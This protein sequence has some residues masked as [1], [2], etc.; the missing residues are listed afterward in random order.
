MLRGLPR[1][2]SAH[3]DGDVSYGVCLLRPIRTALAGRSATTFESLG[4]LLSSHR[5]V[6]RVSLAALS[7]T[8]IVALGQQAAPTIQAGPEPAPLVPE[9]LLPQS[10]GVSV[11]SGDAIT[12]TF[13]T[14]MDPA[15]V[16]AALQVLPAHK[17]E[18]TWNADY[19]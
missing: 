4:T 15:S 6:T 13:E 2:P 14:A 5:A 19:T 11:P 16:E 10:V 7:F 8:I 9:S 12:L 3:T 1:R 18:L 17:V